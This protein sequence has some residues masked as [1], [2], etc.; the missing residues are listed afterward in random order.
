MEFHSKHVWG[1][2]DSNGNVLMTN[3]WYTIVMGE[4]FILLEDSKTGKCVF[5]KDNLYNGDPH[6]PESYIMQISIEHLDHDYFNPWKLI[7]VW[8]IK[9][10][11]EI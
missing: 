3:K 6:N 4:P 1:Y 7:N 8:P 2:C 5:C 9:K 10:K 11:E